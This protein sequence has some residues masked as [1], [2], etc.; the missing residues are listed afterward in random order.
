[1]TTDS[2]R[3]CAVTPQATAFT[4]PRR[5]AA[6][7]LLALCFTAGNA[8]ADGLADLKAALARAQGSSTIS[9]T[10]DA[11]V[12]NR[13]GEGKDA[14]ESTG[15][16]AVY[17]EEGPNGLRLQYSRDTMLRADAEDRAKEKDS[18]S[19][20]PTITGLRALNA[21]EAREMTWASQTLLRNLEKAILKGEKTDTYNGKPARLLSFE[22]GQDKVAEKDRKY[23]KKFDGRLEVWI[24]ADGVPMAS[25]SHVSVSARAF[26]VVSFDIENEEDAAY[27]LAGDRLLMT[28]KESRNKG[29]GAGEKNEG[30]TVRTLSLR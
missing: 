29:S 7:W 1:M 18:K 16:A 8:W 3:A 15:S 13:Q 26:L 9:A 11:K 28:R 5:C 23:V 17:L 4:R 2:T 19:K 21:G 30:K 14:D 22:L 12:W 6:P 20:T 27:T 24:D 25:K 10:F